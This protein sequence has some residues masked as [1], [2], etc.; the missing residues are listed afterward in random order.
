MAGQAV[1]AEMVE[2]Q[3]ETREVAF[4]QLIEGDAAAAVTRLEAELEA[5]PGD[6]AILINLGSAHA[7]LGNYEQAEAYYQAARD[8]DEEYQLELAN[9]RWLDSRDA[10]RLALASVEFEALASR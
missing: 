3:Y 10:A 8:S 4:E 5:N 2:Q 9:G 6:P 1:T 7:Q